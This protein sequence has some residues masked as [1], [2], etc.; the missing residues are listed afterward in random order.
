[1]KSWHAANRRPFDRRLEGDPVLRGLADLISSTKWLPDFV[2]LPPGG[3]MT[4]S[5]T[6]ELEVIRSIPDREIR[7]TLEVSLQHSWIEHDTGWF[8]GRDLGVRLAAALQSVWDDHV[9]P[10][11]GR[12]REALE[13]EVMYRAGLLAA[14]GWP[15][16]LEGMSRRSRWVG[17]DSIRFSDQ[18]GADRFIG[19]EG[20]Q[21][22]PVTLENGTWLCESDAGGYAL[23]YPAKRAAVENVAGDRLALERLIGRGRT[24]ILARLSRPA[25]V[26]ELARELE[27]SL[28]TVGRHL[29]ILRDAGLIVSLRDGHKVVYRIT[30]R[31]AGLLEVTPA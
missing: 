5:L 4:T 29:R 22:V 21:F 15:S 14:F 9:A 7:K 30:D 3:G 31:G 10:D 8:R 6:S 11:W 12:R 20:L 13:R 16:A 2:A 23:V 24:R 28:G 26:S 27:L 1:M 19:D 18:P 25:T 17:S